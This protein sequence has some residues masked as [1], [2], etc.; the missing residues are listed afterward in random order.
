[1]V[2]LLTG[3]VCS[4]ALISDGLLA[5]SHDANLLPGWAELGIGGGFLLLFLADK[6]VTGAKYNQVVKER[7]E[8]RHRT[9]VAESKL[10]EKFLPA[11]LET[12]MTLRLVNDQVLPLMKDLREELEAWKSG[13]HG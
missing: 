3:I 13:N 10:E 2:I 7:D 11:L 5:T 1:M 12:Q 4:I 9:E 8:E 6:I